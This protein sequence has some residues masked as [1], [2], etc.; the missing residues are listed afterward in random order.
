MNKPINLND[1]KELATLCY[2]SAMRERIEKEQEEKYLKRI[3]YLVGANN[4]LMRELEI[5]EGEIITTEKTE[6][7][8]SIDFDFTASEEFRNKGGT[9]VDAGGGVASGDG[10]AKKKRE[11]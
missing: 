8:G 9:S 4:E 1:H 6:V 3:D 7:A 11:S 2:I 10:G 5:C